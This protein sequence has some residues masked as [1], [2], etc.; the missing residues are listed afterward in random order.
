M[1][2]LIDNYDSFTYNLYQYLMAFT[3]VKVVRNDCITIQE[4]REMK[5]EALIISPGPKRPEDAGISMEAIRTFAGEIPIFGICLGHQSI[6]EVFHSPV[7]YAKSLYHGKTS[8]ITQLVADPLFEGMSKVFEGAR[9]HSLVIDP[10]QVSPEL[11]VLATSPDGEIM[12]VKHRDYLV[13]GV[14]FHPES[15]LTREGKRLVE[16]FVQIAKNKLAS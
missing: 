7:V 13:Y 4:I 14:Q 11:T 5:P 12:A 15:I 1:F 6:G 2:L 3:E 9:Y 8:P 10:A 16:N